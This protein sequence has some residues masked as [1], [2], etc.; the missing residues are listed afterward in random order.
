MTPLTLRTP[1]LTLI[2]AT[3][4]H[5]DAELK[6]RGFLEGLLDAAVPDSWPPGEYDIDAIRF[7]RERLIE[8][9]A[10]AEGWYGWYAVADGSAGERRRLVGAAGYFGPP[11]DEGVVEIGYS[12]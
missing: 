8:E 4:Q 7:F 1:R 9:G 12:V 6:G 3:L 5:L 10:A 11:D 2:A